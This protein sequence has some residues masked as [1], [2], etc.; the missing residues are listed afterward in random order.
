MSKSRKLQ[1]RS[2]KTGF[3]PCKETM[4]CATCP[5]KPY[6]TH[7]N[8]TTNKQCIVSIFF[9]RRYRMSI[10]QQVLDGTLDIANLDV[11]RL[12]RSERTALENLL[13]PRMTPYIP[14]VPTPKQAAFMLLDGKEAFYGG[15]A[16]GGKSDALLMCGLQYVDVKGY[17]GIIFRK[18][19]SDLTKPGAL[20]DRSK[21]WLLQFADVRWD[22]K[23]KKFDFIKKYGPHKEVWSILQF[24]YMETANHR[25]NYQGGEY[26][27]IG[28]DE[29]THIHLICYRYMFSR[30]RRLKNVDIP[31]RVRSASNPPD[32]DLGLWVYDRFVN[33]EKKVKDAV[34]IPA[35]MDDNPYLDVEEYAEALEELDPVERARLRDGDWIVKRRGNMFKREFFQIVDTAPKNSRR[36]RFWDMAATDEEKAKRRNKSGEP[37]YTVGLLLSEKD[38]IYYIED[39]VRERKSTANTEALQRACAVADGYRTLV[40]EE[41]EPGSS[42]ISV[43][44]NKMRNLMKGYDYKGIRSTGNKTE[45]AK[46]VSAAAEKGLIK[47]VSTCRFIK[48]FLDEC[49]SFP[50]GLHDDMVDGLSGAFNLLITAPVN[51]FPIGFDSEAGSYWQGD[52]EFSGGYFTKTL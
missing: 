20:I 26:Q 28:W 33:P 36:V 3:C 29:V 35:G 50:G 13:T 9:E 10:L 46:P 23:N 2:H 49:E 37:D 1:W 15:A 5:P 39:I 7:R 8:V 25:F 45:R 24:G 18:T 40:R 47:I 48:E 22:D 43:I 44:D 42:G 31:L 12:S 14:H 41:Q 19:Y 51:G 11:N 6:Y 17:A 16:G 27:F 38:G 4:H 52:E 34:F 32:D 30:L 21:E